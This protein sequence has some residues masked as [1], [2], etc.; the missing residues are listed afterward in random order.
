MAKGII[1]TML[2]ICAVI[3]AG[4]FFHRRNKKESDV[5]GV[6]ELKQVF[7]WIDEVLPLVQKSSGEKFEV[8]ILPNK[9]SQSLAK[10]K[11][12]RVYVAVLQKVT[13]GTQKVMK[14]KVF[15]ANS[16]DEDLSSLNIG[17]II[18]IPIE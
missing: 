10:I 13:D 7:D 3:C 2:C 8:N 9:E 1:D 5:L 11:D 17:N 15:Y 18:V 14:T 16:V 4:Y 6:L 12:K